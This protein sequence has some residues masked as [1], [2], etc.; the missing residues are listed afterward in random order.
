MNRDLRKVIDSGDGV[1]RRAELLTAVPQ[2]VLDHAVR[3]GQLV[4]AF[5][6]VY[7]DPA[8]LA[9]PRVRM[10][11]AL[12]YAGPDAALSHLT[13]LGVWRLPGADLDGPI[14]VL[15]PWPRRL[16]GTGGI[17]LHRR[18]RF[19]AGAP[20]VVVRDG[21]RISRVERCIVDSWP[22][23]PRD[24]GRAAV[25]GAVNDRRTTPSRVLE[26][27]GTNINL[28]GRGELLRLVNLLDRGCRSELELWG[29]QRIFTGPDMPPVE[30]NVRVAL[31][32]RTIQLDAYCRA[33][34]VNFELDG[35][36][37]HTSAADRERDAR[38]DAALAAMGIMVVR[39]THD[40]LVNH[41]AQV[42][43]QIRAIVAARLHAG[44]V[45]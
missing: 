45:G 40:Q 6:C 26:A 4:R 36:K 9:E 22:L 25:I 3:A 42:R 16:R 5:P 38:R 39:F 31:Q 7:A 15:V 35:A 28:P 11:A 20:E 21:L 12:M 44:L 37:W 24:V 33:A 41:P 23:V 43:A 17:V 30:W 19:V 14:H 27:I 1:A 8:R 10:R 29:Y 32:N 18:P 34:R 13:A 2:H